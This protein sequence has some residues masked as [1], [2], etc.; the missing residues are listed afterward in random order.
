MSHVTRKL[1]KEIT[2]TFNRTMKTLPEEKYKKEYS[3]ESFLFKLAQNF[4]TIGRKV[5]L[6]ALELYIT[7]RGDRIKGSQ[8]VLIVAAL[9]YFVTPFDAIPDITPF[10]GYS[11]DLAVLMATTYRIF[12]NMPEE[13]RSKIRDMAMNRTRKMFGQG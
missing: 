1:V 3:E 12:K 7:L 6:P 11:D 2:L 8:K 13:K 4:K 9:G 10:I 5:I